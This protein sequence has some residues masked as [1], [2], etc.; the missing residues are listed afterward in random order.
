MD[1]PVNP[2]VEKGDVK[3]DIVENKVGSEDLKVDNDNTDIS[4]MEEKRIVCQIKLKSPES[5]EKSDLN[6]QKGTNPV[7]I[8]G[9][10]INKDIKTSSDLSSETTDIQVP[11]IV[12]DTS[13]SGSGLKLRVALTDLKVPII[14][15]E[16]CKNVDVKKSLEIQDVLQP[17]K[18]SFQE[19]TK[20]DELNVFQEINSQKLSGNFFPKLKQEGRAKMSAPSKGDHKQ[21][22]ALLKLVM[23]KESGGSGVILKPSDQLARAKA[24]GMSA[25]IANLKSM[26]NSVMKTSLSQVL[27]TKIDTKQEDKSREEEKRTTAN[28]QEETIK[29]SADNEKSINSL[30]IK[31]PDNNDC[32]S[33]VKDCFKDVSPHI[34]TRK[35]CSSDVKPLINV[36]R[37]RKSMPSWSVKIQPVSGTSKTSMLQPVVLTRNQAAKKAMKMKGRKQ[38]R[39][40]F[41]GATYSLY[42]SSKRKK[43]QKKQESTG[44]IKDEESSITGTETTGSFLDSEE[45]GEGGSFISESCYTPSESSFQDEEMSSEQSNISPTPVCKVNLDSAGDDKGN[46]S[47]SN[48]ENQNFEVKNEQKE[49]VEIQDEK[50]RDDNQDNVSVEN[51]VKEQLDKIEKLGETHKY[52]KEEEVII[53]TPSMQNKQEEKE[54]E[55]NFNDGIPVSDETIRTTIKLKTDEARLPVE[56]AAI[57]EST[58]TPEVDSEQII[59]NAA[60]E[61][62]DIKIEKSVLHDDIEIID[63]SNLKDKMEIEETAN[64]EGGSSIAT[65][66]KTRVRLKRRNTDDP[67]DHQWKNDD[68]VSL[69]SSISAGSESAINSVKKSRKMNSDN[70]SS[71][72][73]VETEFI[74]KIDIVVSEGGSSIATIV[75]TRVRLKRRNTDDPQDHQWKNDDTVSLTSSISAGSESAINSVKKS[76]KMNSDNLSSTGHAETEFIPKIY[77]TSYVAASSDHK[78]KKS[79][80][81]H[82]T[83]KRLLSRVDACCLQNGGETT[84]LNVCYGKYNNSIKMVNLIGL[85][86]PLGSAFTPVVAGHCHVGHSL[87]LHHSGLLWQWEAGMFPLLALSFAFWLVVMAPRFN[88]CHNSVQEIVLSTISEKMLQGQSHAKP[89]LIYHNKM[90]PLT[91][92][93]CLQEPLDASSNVTTESKIY[94]QA[95]DSIDDKLIG[96]CNFVTNQKLVR[97]SVRI[98]FT[99]LCE[100]HLWRFR[101]HHC[102]PGCGIFC[103]QGN[104]FQCYTTTDGRPCL[105]LFHKRCQIIQDNGYSPLCPHC[106]SSSDFKSVYL[107]MS[108]PTPP[109]FYLTQKPTLTDT[110]KAK[111]A[112]SRLVEADEA[113]SDDLPSRSFTVPETGK[114]LSSAGLPLGPDRVQLEALLVS[115]ATEKSLC[116]RYNVKNLYEPAKEGDV[117]KVLHLLTTGIDPDSKS[118]ENE[119]ET[120]LHA[121]ASGGHLVIVHLLVQAGALMD[122]MDDHLCTPL[123]LA[124]EK[125]QVAVAQYL[126][127]AGAHL[128][129]RDEGGWTPIVWASEHKHIDVIRLLLERGADPNIR[130]NEG[131]IALHWSK[132]NIT[133]NYYG[134]EGMT[135]LH[136]ASR[137]GSVK[138]CKMILDTGRIN[139]NIQDEGGWTPIVWASEHKHIDVIRLLLERGA[140]PNIRDNVTIFFYAKFEDVALCV[141]WL[142]ATVPCDDKN[143]IDSDPENVAR[144]LELITNYPVISEIDISR[145][146]ELNPIQCV[147]GIDGEPAPT[148][149]LYVTENC[150]T[151][152]IHVDR[153]ITSLQSCR[154][155]DDCTS[156]NCTCATISFKC[157]YD[158]EGHLL[159]EFNML[160]PPMIFECNRACLCWKNCNNRVLQHGVTSRLQL[161]RT[162][163]KGWG[164]RALKEIPKG[165]FICEY[166]GEIISDSE[167]DQREDDSYLFDLDN[168]DGETYCLDARYYGNISRFINHLCE[169][170]LVPVKIFVDHQD[171]SFPRIAFFSS[172]DIKPL[173]ELGFD[174]GEKFWVIKYKWFTCG[175]G[176]PKCKYSKETIHE[177]LANYYRR[178]KEE[179]VDELDLNPPI[180]CPIMP[181]GEC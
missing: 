96:C 163:Q 79:L 29:K 40:H 99:A 175:C 122:Q 68:T 17:S 147:N 10:H 52:K 4:I 118:E 33:T 47:T 133:D 30:S 135:A 67:Q 16:S 121:A 69:T 180:C 129:A 152:P 140:D 144:Q 80:Y 28:E 178:L 53:K 169:P 50:L 57:A 155:D 18:E 119:H 170:N 81:A 123:M 42:L 88:T 38:K 162:K 64:S 114:I 60:V 164:V 157:W 174:Y 90:P 165:S 136:L 49:K 153:T 131:N 161:F 172:R 19:S 127:K 179:Q 51:V 65:I 56:D 84:L 138:M 159:P 148:D 73:H 106:G 116:P 76:R 130:D 176:S 105:H 82:P 139:V 25:K 36:N 158:K 151:S 173:E 55:A 154:C 168:R 111:M 126:I 9:S 156:P 35:S 94:C 37:A 160:D 34:A 26:L 78:W 134:E 11:K 101:H 45:E 150:E 91:S 85:S 166:I 71:T 97:P 177:T 92:C 93:T 62:E 120:P 48:N 137:C 128:D 89:P 110:P 83:R 117:D 149:F 112:F 59:E 142:T 39:R 2:E 46:L 108:A 23:S 98:P 14:K 31:S 75:K 132:I 125:K 13:S 74:P 22:E 167:A 7:I 8:T 3:T 12:S 145:G 100:S 86:A 181:T 1:L 63:T 15:S 104:F 21:N 32:N 24:V 20:L 77:A 103:T 43:K 61:R 87:T 107:E 124:V 95:L 102:C 109:A 113:E 27:R 54:K 72:G 6:K 5:T 141:Q 115:L 146:K 171:L 58:I 143:H 44:G 41:R 70:L 66:V